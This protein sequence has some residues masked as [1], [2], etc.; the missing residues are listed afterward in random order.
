MFA[1]VVMASAE[2][3]LIMLVLA[4]SSV[5]DIAKFSEV[6]GKQTRLASEGR[7]RLRLPRLRGRGHAAVREP[8]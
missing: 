8:V 4:A 1:K 3:D 7:V 5:V 6:P 2:R